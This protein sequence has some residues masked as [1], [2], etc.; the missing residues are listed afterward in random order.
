M[1]V[2]ERGKPAPVLSVGKIGTIPIAILILLTL[3]FSQ[4]SS[5]AT[6]K[7]L[8]GWHTDGQTFLVWEHPDEGPPPS[9]AYMIYSS[10]YPIDRVDEAERV[11]MVSSGNGINLR[12]QEFPPVPDDHWILPDEFGGNYLLRDNEA[13]FVATPHQLRSQYYA[14]VSP[15]DDDVI[16]GQNSLIAPIDETT[17]PVTCH[18]QFQNDEVT[19]YAHWIDGGTDDDP[20]RPDYPLMGNE[21]SNGIGFN[22]AVWE[23]IDGRP[24]DPLPTVIWL[25]GAGQSFVD[26]TITNFAP[27]LVPGGLFVTLDDPLPIG[28]LSEFTGIT[29]WWGYADDFNRFH[30]GS[31]PDNSATIIDYTARRVRWTTKWLKDNEQVD[32]HRISL[33]GYS[34]GGVGAL[35]HSQLRSDLFAAGVAY[36]PPLVLREARGADRFFTLFGSIEQDL[37]TN[38]EGE[39]GIWDLLD[40][41]WRIQ[42]P[43]PDWP[44][45]LIVCGKNDNVAPWDVNAETYTN[46]DSA[47][48]GYA[49]YWDER[50]HSDWEDV[51][52]QPSLHLSPEYLSRFRTKQSFPAFSKTDLYPDRA[53]RQPDPGNG[54][55]LDGDP[56]GTWGGYLEWDTEDIVDLPDRWECTIWITSESPYECD[57]PESDWIIAS[58]TPRNLQSFTSGQ[59]GNRLHDILYLWKVI[60][61]SNG[62]TLQQ[63]V[64]RVKEDG[65]ITINGILFSKDPYRLI[66]SAHASSNEH[67]LR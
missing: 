62:T 58:V 67:F 17:D 63:G 37:K 32:H 29:F 53:G 4:A 39:P 19:I 9:R 66:I 48:T 12:L 45:V 43:H 49:L 56:W 35:L 1:T 64:V 14:V 3:S 21:Y 55:P 7:N 61:L 5:D 34:M 40:Q 28:F 57:I 54:D 2:R 11:A 52:F 13:F 36:V 16:Q 24:A 22:F 50:G 25:H 30:P 42:Q 18:I 60:D 59:M 20:G 41:G 38:L 47:R 33:A 6:P 51:H 31:M 46:L 26:E 15:E 23:P 10:P 27:Y 44:Y 65:T 8:R